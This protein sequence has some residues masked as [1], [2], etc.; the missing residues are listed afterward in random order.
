MPSHV[1]LPGH[2]SRRFV[3]DHLA[4]M[5]LETEMRP[6][7]IHST[8]EVDSE[9]RRSMVGWPNEN[10]ELIRLAT[11][12]AVAE[13]RK[14][15]QFDLDGDG[16][17]QLTHYSAEDAG[18]YHTHIDM[19]L[20][21][22]KAKGRKLSF[23]LQLSDGGDYF[24]GDLTLFH[25]GYAGS[26][27]GAGHRDLDRVPV[28]RGPFRRPAR[29]RGAMVSRVVAFGAAIPLDRSAQVQ[30]PVLRVE[31]TVVHKVYTEQTALIPDW[32]FKC[33]GC[34][35][36]GA[37]PARP[38]PIPQH[39]QP[40]PHCGRSRQDRLP[41]TAAALHACARRG[42]RPRDPCLPG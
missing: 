9:T 36:F 8:N 19:S 42:C 14:H 31:L 30:R 40:L 15:W 12:A 18:V 39:H 16:E 25:V 2:F 27:A 23:V 5:H 41:C 3:Q 38:R 17:H 13:N 20:D 35:Q 33:L 32:N 24:G 22:S 28:V 4:D 21:S 34:C 10:C 6:A 11:A 1:I 7:G 26:P 29:S 37:R